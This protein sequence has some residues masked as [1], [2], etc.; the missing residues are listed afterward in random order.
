[1]TLGKDGVTTGASND[2]QRATSFARSMVAK[3]G[4]TD[5]MG[6]LLYDEEE[7]DPFNRGY[8]QGAK[9]LAEETQRKIDME[10]RKI[11]D[12]CYKRAEKILVDNRDIL[13]SM[14]A[15]LMKYETID[16]SQIDELMERQPVSPPEGWVEGD[17]SEG[18]T[19]SASADESAKPSS[20]DVDMNDDDEGVDPDVPDSSD[21]N[22]H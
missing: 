16:S 2:I 22:I 8:G 17:E 19:P 20:D 9:P 3:W 18:D 7:S 13:E 5:E 1:M 14:C 4:L 6:P 12:E 15:A 10:T 11:I 21:K